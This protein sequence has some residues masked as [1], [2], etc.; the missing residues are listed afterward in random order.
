M[1][2]I[3]DDQLSKDLQKTRP[4]QQNYVNS[5]IREKEEFKPFKKTENRIDDDYYRQLHRTDYTG[6]P[7]VN[8]IRAPPNKA[9]HKTDFPNLQKD[10]KHTVF[11]L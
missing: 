1:V 2:Y 5:K 10:L 11:C 8:K 7:T 3:F 9:G 6:I 4:L